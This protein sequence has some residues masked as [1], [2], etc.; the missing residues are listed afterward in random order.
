MCNEI[1]RLFQGYFPPSGKQIQGTDTCRFI[2]ISKLPAGKKA[3]YIRIVTADRLIKEE[4][5]RVR[6]TVG[7]DQ[8]DY[9]GDCT[10]KEAD[11]VTAKVLFN[12]VISTDNTKFMNLD[13]KDFYLGTILPTKEYIRIPV[14]IIPQETIVAYNLQDLI[15]KGYHY[16][17][18]IKCKHQANTQAVAV[19]KT[20]DLRDLDLTIMAN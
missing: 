16:A 13:V 17:E 6:M 4:Q 20:E 15:H 12:S 19:F 2:K 7:G 1:G 10:T 8:V 14:A 9:P 18:V 11:L 5:R 3:P